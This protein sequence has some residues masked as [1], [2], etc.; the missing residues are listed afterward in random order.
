MSRI[1][2]HSCGI[3]F[4]RVNENGNP[5]VFLGET[6]SPY[7]WRNPRL[8]SWGLPKGGREDNET[9]L[10]SAK[11][12]LMEETGVLAPEIQYTVLTEYRTTYGKL[13]TVFIA[14]TT[15]LDIQ[16]QGSTTLQTEWPKGSGEIISYPEM[17]DAQ[18]L[19]LG[20]AI[21]KVMGSQ[22]PILHQFRTWFFPNAPVRPFEAMSR[23]MV[24][25][26]VKAI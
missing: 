24:Q 26:S 20:E 3:L 25:S 16:F 12:E 2:D 9:L 13:I 5:E 6:N 23:L 19:Q 21:A 14:D 17:K 8:P 11:R 1:S 4:Y 10:E 15:G 7:F 22:K 18:W